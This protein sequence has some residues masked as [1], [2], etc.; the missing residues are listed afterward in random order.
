MAKPCFEIV[1]D[2]CGMRSGVKV[3]SGPKPQGGASFL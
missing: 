1:L 2:Y 3:R